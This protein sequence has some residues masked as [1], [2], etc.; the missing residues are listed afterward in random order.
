MIEGHH[1]SLYVRV[2]DNIVL[3]IILVIMGVVF[4]VNMRARSQIWRLSVFGDI[5]MAVESKE[6]NRDREGRDPMI[7]F[8]RTIDT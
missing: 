7:E 5:I 2:L 6:S 1:R 3:F 4:A 8:E